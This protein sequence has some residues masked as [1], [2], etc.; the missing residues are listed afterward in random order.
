[1]FNYIVGFC[2]IA[3]V[4]YDFS[5]YHFLDGVMRA[6][7]TFL[8]LFYHWAHQAEIKYRDSVDVSGNPR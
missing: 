8:L 2:G 1:M 7:I 6:L 4:I 3:A 5:N